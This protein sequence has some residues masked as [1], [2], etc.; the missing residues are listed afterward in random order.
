MTLMSSGNER[1]DANERIPPKEE[2]MAEKKTKT[3]KSKKV[4]PKPKREKPQKEDRTGWGVFAFR[5]PVSERNAF[6]TAAGP[7]GAS[8]TMRALAGAFVTGDPA[9]FESIVE[10]AKKLQ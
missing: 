3:T 4:E 1:T 8:R 7:A 10:D 6:H 2:P 9:A 5:L